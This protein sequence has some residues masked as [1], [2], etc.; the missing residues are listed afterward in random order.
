MAQAQDKAKASA[1]APR[2]VAPKSS[3]EA[4]KPVDAEKEVLTTSTSGH[5]TSI[6][7]A[8]QDATTSEEDAPIMGR[9]STAEV[10]NAQPPKTKVSDAQPLAAKSALAAIQEGD[11]KSKITLFL[12]MLQSATDASSLGT[13]SSY[14]CASRAGHDAWKVVKEKALSQGVELTMQSNGR[15]QAWGRSK[16]KRYCV[17]DGGWYTLAETMEFVFKRDGDYMFA[18]RMWKQMAAAQPPPP[19]SCSASS[20]ET[21]QPCNRG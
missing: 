21:Q 12:N 20:R 1:A 6:N 5:T 4:T 2:V 19:N 18:M 8:P 15:I 11:E 3:G 14:W 9:L 13:T 17:E 10:V 16:E 7:T